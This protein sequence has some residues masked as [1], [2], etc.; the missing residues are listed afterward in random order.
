M[1]SIQPSR[2]FPFNVI[3]KRGEDVSFPDYKDQQKA[4]KRILK[5]YKKGDLIHTSL[6]EEE[7]FTSDGDKV[8]RKIGKTYIKNE[9]GA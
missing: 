4:F 5:F 8:T 1:D 7:R 6:K 9:S 2:V 3:A